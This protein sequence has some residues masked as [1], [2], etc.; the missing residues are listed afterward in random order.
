MSG[1]LTKVARW[2]YQ[3]SNCDRRPRQEQQ[4]PLQADLA[5]VATV[6]VIVCVH[7]AFKLGGWTLYA[8]EFNHK[9][10]LLTA[11]A[12]RFSAILVAGPLA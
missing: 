2:A 6:C 3:K 4:R 11:C 7:F 8:V 12:R 1:G 10:P 9:W 5:V